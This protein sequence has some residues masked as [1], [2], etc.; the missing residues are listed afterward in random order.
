MSM[1]KLF[2]VENGVKCF[3]GNYDILMIENALW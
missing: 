3:V 2:Q 1:E